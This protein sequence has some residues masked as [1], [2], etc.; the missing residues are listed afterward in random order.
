MES[1]LGAATEVLAAHKISGIYKKNQI[2][3]GQ[4][5]KPFWDSGTGYVDTI[6]IDRL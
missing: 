4:T 5:T 6:D 1:F 2:N 3:L